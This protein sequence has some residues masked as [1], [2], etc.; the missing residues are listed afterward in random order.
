MSEEWI[1]LP[2]TSYFLCAPSDFFI[3]VFSSPFQNLWDPR[4]PAAPACWRHTNDSYITTSVF[5]SY[6]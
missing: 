1:N 3:L 4:S 6:R 2:C 5:M